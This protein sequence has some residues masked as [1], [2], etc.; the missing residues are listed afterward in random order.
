MPSVPYAWTPIDLKLSKVSLP[1]GRVLDAPS[2]FVTSGDAVWKTVQL[3][4]DIDLEVLQVDPDET[5]CLLA[6]SRLRKRARELLQIFTQLRGE[7]LFLET[8]WTLTGFCVQAKNPR[9]VKAS[10]S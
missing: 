9:S 4:E 1:D 7:K 10:S 2:Y 6:L 3:I 8:E 5:A